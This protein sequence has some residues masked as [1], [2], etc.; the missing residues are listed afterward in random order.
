[1]NNQ[2]QNETLSLILLT[3]VAL[4]VGSGITCHVMRKKQAQQE[5]HVES[6]S[7]SIT[8]EDVVKKIDEREKARELE[9]LEKERANKIAALSNEMSESKKVLGDVTLELSS[10]YEE[11]KKSI[12]TLALKSASNSASVSINRE[13]KSQLDTQNQIIIQLQK[14]VAEL[15]LKNKEVST[16]TW[17]NDQKLNE[18]ISLLKKGSQS[19]VQDSKIVVKPSAP[20]Q[21]VKRDVLPPVTPQV[22]KVEAVRNYKAERLSVK[23]NLPPDYE[24][25]KIKYKNDELK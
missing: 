4:G 19:C 22:N 21:E 7:S 14:Q 2:S 16:N 18:V 9:K 8:M 17:V 15:S 10:K 24:S 1:M 3:V 25:P 12:D 6:K 13:L 11:L 5:V 20:S 23:S